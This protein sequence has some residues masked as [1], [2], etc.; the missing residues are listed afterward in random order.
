MTDHATPSRKT[1]PILAVALIG[2]W[3]I[4]GAMGED[5]RPPGAQ[6][7]LAGGPEPGNSGSDGRVEGLHDHLFQR[8]QRVPGHPRLHRGEVQ[9]LAAA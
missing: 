8:S 9:D 7:R 2:V 6:D 3:G 1:L 4:V 5:L